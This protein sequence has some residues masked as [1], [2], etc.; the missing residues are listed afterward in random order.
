LKRLASSQSE[1]GTTPRPCGLA[2]ANTPGSDG[3]P[4]RSRGNV[5]G[6]APT[7]IELSEGATANRTSPSP[8]EAGRGLGRGAF[9]VEPSPSSPRPSPPFWGGEGVLA[10][11]RLSKILN[12]MAVGLAPAWFGVSTR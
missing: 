2:A 1:R 5:S 6:P 7:A 11:E 12:S 3:R 4:A 10:V 9:L 8:C